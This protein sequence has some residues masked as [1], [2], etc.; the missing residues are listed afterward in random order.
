[1]MDAFLQIP[2]LRGHRLHG[3]IAA[4]QGGQLS[5]LASEGHKLGD[6][7][8]ITAARGI[9]PRPHWFGVSEED[10]PA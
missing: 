6:E 8:S 1:M 7:F 5:G 9:A 3:M 10:V 4:P 2:D